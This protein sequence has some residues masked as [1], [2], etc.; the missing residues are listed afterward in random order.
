MNSLSACVTM[1]TGVR[2]ATAQAI[3][4]LSMPPA[5]LDQWAAGGILSPKAF[6]QGL[7]VHVL[8]THSLNSQKV[9]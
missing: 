2:E 5:C 7:P 9:S 3:E 6:Q 4:P 1:E 8:H